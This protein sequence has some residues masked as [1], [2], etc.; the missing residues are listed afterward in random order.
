MSKKVAIGKWGDELHDDYE[1]LLQAAV[2]EADTLLKLASPVDT[3]RFRSSWQIGEGAHAQDSVGFYDAD[4]TGSLAGEGKNKGK[5]SPPKSPMPPPKGMNYPVGDE[6]LG[7]SYT[8]HN[9]LPYAEVLADGHSKQAPPGWV[10]QV[11]KDVQSWLEKAT[12]G[13]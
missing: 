5:T 1:K 2:L 10:D 9:S 11:A 4:P 6:K 12:R 13:N 3:G 7:L 8:L